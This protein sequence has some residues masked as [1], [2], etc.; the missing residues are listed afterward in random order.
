M[1]GAPF[2]GHAG[3]ASV[4][5]RGKEGRK[6]RQDEV[7]SAALRKFSKAYGGGVGW[8]GC[9]QAKVAWSRNPAPPRS[10]FLVMTGSSPRKLA[11]V[12]S[13]DEQQQIDFRAQRL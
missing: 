5:E 7:P 12:P 2:E 13:W 4:Q 3:V 10:S 9:P 1:T 6:A 11:S 8:G